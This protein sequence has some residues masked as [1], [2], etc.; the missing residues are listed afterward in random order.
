MTKEF[1]IYADESTKK[2]AYYSNF[3]GGVLIRSNDIDVVRST[4]K[5]AKTEQN[6][7]NE[8]KW[9]RVT[10]NY[11]T[12]YMSLMDTFFALVQQDQIK[13]RVMF[14][15]NINVPTKFRHIPT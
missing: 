11:L 5:T 3:Y 2:G 6:L 4:L 9:S 1:L 10:A 14:T 7:F 8:I 12:K 15:Q 13:M